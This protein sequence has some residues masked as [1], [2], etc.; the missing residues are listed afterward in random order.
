M[1]SVFL[2]KTPLQLLNAIEARYHFKLAA[3]ECVLIIMGDRKSQP[4]LLKLASATDEWGDVVVLN[5]VDLLFSNPFD[6]SANGFLKKIQNISIL[7]KSF[8]NVRRLNR[9]SRKLGS[10]K[11]IFVGYAR[12]IYMKHFV[13]IM[14]HEEV[15]FL[16]DGNATIDLA[17]ERNQNRV[18]NPELGLKKTLKLY[19]KKLLQGVKDKDLENYNFFT[20]YEISPAENDQVIKNSFKHLR[21]DSASLV[22]TDDVYFLGGPISECGIISQQSYFAHLKRVKAYFADK[23]VIYIAH[24]RESPEK[25]TEIEN[26]FGLKVVLFDYPIEYQLAYVG[27][28]PK[29]LASF[30]SSALDSCRIIFDDQLKI[31]SFK[32][33]LTGSPMREEIEPIYESYKT[34]VN[35]FFV[36]ELNY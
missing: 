11:Y 35:D 2:V 23:N 8:F 36:V 7:K 29:V 12:Y 26:R 3:D 17:R 31:V 6:S 20:M 10:V 33:D 1:K 4:Q 30:I 24:R 25:L 13:N 19:G 27:P 28:R 14:P 5:D 32:M 15:Y 18:L 9:I 21:S 34:L 16:D 22:K